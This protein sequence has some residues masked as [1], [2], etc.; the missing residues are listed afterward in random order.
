MKQLDDEVINPILMGI[1]IDTSLPIDKIREAITVY[2]DV[3]ADMMGENKPYEFKIDY[4][5]KIR[6]KKR[7]VDFLEKRKEA[8]ESFDKLNK[9]DYGV[10]QS[11]SG[12]EGSGVVTGSKDNRTIQN[13]S[14]AA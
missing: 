11:E 12:N 14:K 7:L 3:I 10:L 13:I 9:R 5:G 2:Y 4:F 6:A 8:V 1:A